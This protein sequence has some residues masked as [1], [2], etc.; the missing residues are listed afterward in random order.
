MFVNN[1]VGI[2]AMEISY[3]FAGAASG[4]KEQE[5]GEESD[6]AILERYTRL[7]TTIIYKDLREETTK[8]PKLG[9]ST[10]YTPLML[11]VNGDDID[12]RMDK[13]P[14]TAFDLIT[15]WIS[16][17]PTFTPCYLHRFRLG[18]GRHRIFL[19]IFDTLRID[20]V[21][22]SAPPSISTPPPS[23]PKPNMRT[24]SPRRRPRKVRGHDHEAVRLGTYQMRRICAFG[25]EGRCQPCTSDRKNKWNYDYDYDC[26]QDGDGGSIHL[27][28]RWKRGARRRLE[29]SRLRV[30]LAELVSDERSQPTL[31]I[32]THPWP[33]LQSGLAC[34]HAL[35]FQ[36]ACVLSHIEAWRPA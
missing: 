22:T 8:P 34:C 14:V 5:Q 27:D 7:S 11:A 33:L 4:G 12:P 26:D 31:S 13:R 17:F 36:L 9:F 21:P 15:G 24:A 29:R 1:V 23:V 18:L 16:N 19:G 25:E 3:G 35:E 32:L 28:I 2:E 6:T 20:I 30:D 10:S